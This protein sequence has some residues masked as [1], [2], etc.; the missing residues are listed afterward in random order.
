MIDIIL[1][2]PWQQICWVLVKGLAA[3]CGVGLLI[4]LSDWRGNI[5]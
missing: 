1:N 2:L 3:G 4:L 5:L